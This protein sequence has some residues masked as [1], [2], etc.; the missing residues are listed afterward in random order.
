MVIVKY[1]WHAAKLTGLTLV[2]ASY[3]LFD[4]WMRAKHS[5]VT[6]QSVVARV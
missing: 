1:D 4:R 3:A 5:Q 2:F 6:V